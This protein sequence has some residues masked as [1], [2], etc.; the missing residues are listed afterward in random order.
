MI[1]SSLRLEGDLSL[2]LGRGLPPQKETSSESSSSESSESD[3]QVTGC[4]LCSTGEADRRAR[5][6]PLPCGICAVIA[7]S[8]AETDVPVR[9]GGPID[10][11]LLP[12][13]N[14]RAGWVEECDT[15][16]ASTAFSVV[17]ESD[18]GVLRIRSIAVLN[19]SQLDSFRS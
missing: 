7:A 8:T 12:R 5:W 1:S 9:N 17:V 2:S 10:S 11:E 15:S 14:G 4:W 19:E 6:T 3:V 18:S 16:C 13:V